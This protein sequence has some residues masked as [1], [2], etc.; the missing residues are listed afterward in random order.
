MKKIKQL[1]QHLQFNQIVFSKIFLNFTTKKIKGKSF[2]FQHAL[3][4]LKI[5]TSKIYKTTAIT[6]PDDL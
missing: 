3:N 5:I 2:F 1:L 6:S 4:E